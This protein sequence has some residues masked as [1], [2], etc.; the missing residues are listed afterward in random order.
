MNRFI[1]LSIGQFAFA[2]FLAIDGPLRTSAYL[3]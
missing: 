1:W 2:G 3:A